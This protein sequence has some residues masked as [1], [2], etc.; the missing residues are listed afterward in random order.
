VADDSAYAMTLAE[1]MAMLRRDMP[2]ARARRR[3]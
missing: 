2:F 3:W 1:D